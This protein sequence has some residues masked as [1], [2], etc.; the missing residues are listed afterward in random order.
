MASPDD[1]LQAAKTL[2]R[3]EVLRQVY[4]P[5]RVIA[6]RLMLYYIPHYE[7][8]DRP[9]ISVRNAVSALRDSGAI[10][11]ENMGGENWY[12][13]PRAKP[14]KLQLARERKP[15]VY[16]AWTTALP[17]GGGHAEVLW[18]AAFEDEGWV[19]PDRAV[20]VRCPDPSRALHTE[21]HEI[22]VY[23][24]LGGSYTVACEVKNGA[25]EGWVDPQLP[26]K[27]KITKQQLMVLHH[28]EAMDAMSLVPML[29]APFVD[30][31]F[32]RFQARHGGVHARY[33]YHVFDP[34][35]AEV[36]A[37]VKETFRIGH[38]W[39]EPSP[40]QNFRLF[41]RRLPEMIETTREV[42]RR[43]EEAGDE[44]DSSESDPDD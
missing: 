42:G 22:D 41:V 27:V 14:E 13:L 28:F 25:A 26:S 29:A 33:L 44:L 6:A 37:A 5:L 8:F 1:Q 35:D 3:R 24:T 17:R 38:V 34:R 18:R 30:P 12:H 36:A 39:A 11:P 19:V 10:V 2:V 23:A 20:Q 9:W 43:M 21:R 32:Y 4:V 16:N 31:S 40:P 7:G 15:P